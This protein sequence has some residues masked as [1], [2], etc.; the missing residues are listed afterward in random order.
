ME[1]KNQY[2]YQLLPPLEE[3]DKDLYIRLLELHPG[4]REGSITCSL[5]QTRLSKAQPYEALSY[6]WGVSEQPGTIYVTSAPSS[7]VSAEGQPLQVPAS[8]IPFLY[9]TR[10]HPL[11]KDETRLLWIDSICINQN[12]NDEKNAQVANMREIYVLAKHTII[13]LGTEA[14]QSSEALKYAFK[15]SRKLLFHEAE[16]QKKTLSPEEEKEREKLSRLKVTIA[17]MPTS[18]FFD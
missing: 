15:L 1:V 9:R 12:D 4:D 11:Y 17:D 16:Q 5:I 3:C 7:G 18:K 2:Q 13:W 8:L 14:D 10:A 6:C